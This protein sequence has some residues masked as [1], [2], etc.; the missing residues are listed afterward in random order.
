MSDIGKGCVCGKFSFCDSCFQDF[1]DFDGPCDLLAEEGVGV[2]DNCDVWLCPSCPTQVAN[3]YFCIDGAKGK[4]WPP[5]SNTKSC[6]AP[7]CWE[8]KKEHACKFV[9]P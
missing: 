6:T 2:C 8:Q 9:W 1:R 7:S 3:L 4:T 5:T